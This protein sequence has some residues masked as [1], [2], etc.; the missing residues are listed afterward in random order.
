MMPSIRIR[1]ATEH[2]LLAIIQLDGLSNP[3]PWGKALVADALITRKNWVIESEGEGQVSL[4]GWLTASVLFD[5]SE[6]ELIVVAQ[7]MRRQGLAKKL[8]VTWL[9]AVAEQGV[10]EYLLEVRESNLGAINLYQSLGFELVGHRKNYYQ[11]EG[12]HEAACLFNL[13]LNEGN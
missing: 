13:K 4:A 7:K 8:M 3:Y 10:C 6:L 9:H 1:P 2:D 11:T 5:Q 12:G